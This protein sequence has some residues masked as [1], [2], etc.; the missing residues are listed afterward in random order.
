GSGLA[1]ATAGGGPSLPCCSLGPSYSRCAP[2]PPRP[3]ASR[4]RAPL[5][6]GRRRRQQP[7]HLGRYPLPL[8]PGR[9]GRRSVRRGPAAGRRRPALAAPTLRL[10]RAAG[11][12]RRPPWRLP[13]LRPVPRDALGAPP[14][15][16]SRRPRLQLLPALSALAG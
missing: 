4:R 9:P 10:E 12:R 11:A 1:T 6:G 5:S 14:R 13:V 3:A 7:G 15:S 16:G 2:G 8:P